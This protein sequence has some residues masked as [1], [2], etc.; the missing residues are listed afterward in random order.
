MYLSLSEATGLTDV[1]FSEDDQSETLEPWEWIEF[2]AGVTGTYCLSVRLRSG[3]QPSWI[4]LQSFTSQDLEYYSQDRS[5]GEPA[6]SA[7]AG[8]LAVGA[9]LAS[10]TSTIEDFSSRG[11]T[12]DGRTK[13]DIVGADNIHSAAYGEAF[14]GTS[15]ASPHVAGL[16]VLV[17]QRFPDYTPEQVASYLEN[18]AEERGD[19]GADNIWGHGFARLLA[20]DAT[21]PAPS[22]TPSAD[23]CVEMVDADSSTDGTWSSDCES[24]HSDRSGHYARYYT[25][26]LTES[27]EVTVTLESTT[28]PYLYLREGVGREGSVLC[29]N[30]D[31]GSSVTGLSCSGISSSLDTTTD[32]GLVASLAEG[33][34]TIE[35]TTYDAAATGD[36]TITLTTG[37]ATTQ[38]T[39]SPIPSPTPVPLP[40]DYDIKDYACTEDDLADLE[41]YSFE[42]E[43]GPNVYDEGG[44][45]GLIGRYWNSWVNEEADAFIFCSVEQYD[46]IENARWSSLNYSR[47]ILRYGAISRILSHSLAPHV[48]PYV[49]DDMLALWLSFEYEG[50]DDFYT[51]A[52]VRF[53]D[54]S[55]LT[56]SRVFYY[57]RNSEEYPKLSQAAGI[58]RKIESRVFPTE[59]DESESQRT[60]SSYGAQEP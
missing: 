48:S 23:S 44:Y 28:D 19:I 47:I 58:A 29:E 6:D 60:Q 54:S 30:D 25:F 51:A 1:D 55:T 49:G 20:S 22:P 5:I 2:T 39:P 36:F 16:A 3:S 41:G 34:Y 40:P 31:Y 4:Q 9:A 7:N 37:A 15:Q 32:S 38:P 21:T 18:H 11:P 17:K 26:S 42:A 35:A 24:S 14:P 57:F 46:S 59:E 12:L 8:L 52:E 53:L 45:S 56:T 27:A 43:N 50:E 33:S 13:P 10:D